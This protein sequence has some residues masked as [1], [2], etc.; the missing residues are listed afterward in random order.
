MKTK[1]NKKKDVTLIMSII[2]C[3]GDTDKLAS[4][5]II[6]WRDGHKDTIDINGTSIEL[7][8]LIAQHH[9]LTGTDDEIIRKTIVHVISVLSMSRYVD[10]PHEKRETLI[11]DLYK[12][13]LPAKIA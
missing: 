6:K 3:E 2:G 1:T 9:P 12:K 11:A 7:E 8:G 13:Y 5:S 4:Q 10:G